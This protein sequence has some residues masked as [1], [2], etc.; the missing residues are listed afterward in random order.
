MTW[1]ALG[2]VVTQTSGVPVS[3]YPFVLAPLVAVAALGVILLMCRWVFSVD[4][5][6]DRTAR[7][8]D[9][10]AS[11]GDYGLLVP[12][13]R[14]RV[15]EDAQMLRSVLVGAGIR[16]SVTDEG[17]EYAVLVFRQDAVRARSLVGTSS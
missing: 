11:A 4:H 2:G 13:A 17:L 6:E 15:A 1:L 8:L 7:R 16:A 14:V 12:V 10:L 5:R 3:S 9:K